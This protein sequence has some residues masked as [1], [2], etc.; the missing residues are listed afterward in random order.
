[1]KDSVIERAQAGAAVIISSHMLELVED[2]C[3]HLLIIH[4]GQSLYFGGIDDARAAFADH[5]GDASLEEVF[6]RVTEGPSPPD[7]PGA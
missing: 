1:M 4:H 3:T 6:F 7:E 5:D 2:L